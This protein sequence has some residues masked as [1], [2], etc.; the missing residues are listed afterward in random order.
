MRPYFRSDVGE[1]SRE[2]ILKLQNI[3]KSEGEGQHP[4]ETFQGGAGEREVSRGTSPTCSAGGGMGPVFRNDAGHG[5]R[6]H[7]MQ[8][9]EAMASF[10]FI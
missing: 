2:V 3:G 10:H 4:E 6:G 8:H 5:S 1:F 9:L 7:I